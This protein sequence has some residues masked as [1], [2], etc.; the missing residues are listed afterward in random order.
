MLRLITF[1]SLCACLYAPTTLANTWYKVEVI[2]V[3]YTN[4]SDINKEDW[5][6]QPDPIP[7]YTTKPRINWLSA[8]QSKTLN[9][10]VIRRLGKPD[11]KTKSAEELLS[12]LKPETLSEYAEKIGELPHTKVLYHQSWLEPI[13]SKKRASAHSLTLSL[14]N[15]DDPVIKINGELTL[16]RSR[17]LHIDTDFYVQHYDKTTPNQTIENEQE[18]TVQE[19]ASTTNPL[20]AIINNEQS[21]KNMEQA[22]VLTPIRAA[23]IKL[24]RRMRSNELHYIDHP[25]LGIVIKTTPVSQL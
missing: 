23:Q 17:Y 7:T 5:P 24:S 4:I 2:L 25:M 21:N 11:H 19:T 13:Q 16:Y 10:S 22:T 14:E 18:N 15:E 9:Q 3:A 12:A 6:I 1:I 8:N 20:N